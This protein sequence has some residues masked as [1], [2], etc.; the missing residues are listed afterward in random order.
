MKNPKR[1]GPILDEEI[2]GLFKPIPISRSLKADSEVYKFARDTK[3]DI[4]TFNQAIREKNRL[5]LALVNRPIPPQRI[6]HTA[7]VGNFSES[8]RK[9]EHPIDDQVQMPVR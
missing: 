7:F 2:Q 5:W 1:T 3:A 6:R 4:Q 8:Q 9:W